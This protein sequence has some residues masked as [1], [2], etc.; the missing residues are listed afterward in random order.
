MLKEYEFRT[1]VIL[2]SVQS[3]LLRKLKTNNI[4]LNKVKNLKVYEADPKLP[5]QQEK[6]IR[7]TNNP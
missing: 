4:P 3:E 6:G 2:D 5:H 1:A 7:C